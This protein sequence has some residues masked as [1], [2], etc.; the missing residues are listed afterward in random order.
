MNDFLD[1]TTG[2]WALAGASLIPAI[3]I[4]LIVLSAAV[5][6]KNKEAHHG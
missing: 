2:A 4:A 3:T 6:P 1:Y 5:L